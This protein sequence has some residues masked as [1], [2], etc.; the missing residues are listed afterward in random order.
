[1]GDEGVGD[2][3]RGGNM[4]GNFHFNEE[5]LIFHQKFCLCFVFRLYCSVKVYKRYSNALGAVKPKY[6]KG[7]I[8]YLSILKGTGSSMLNS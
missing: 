7:Q 8:F 1:M 3:S 6:L 5:S 4:R 2:I